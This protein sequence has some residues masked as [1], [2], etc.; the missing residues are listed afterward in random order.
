MNDPEK[1]FKIEGITELWKVDEPTIIDQEIAE[2][3]PKGDDLKT[4]FF[5]NNFIPNELQK[6]VRDSKYVGMSYK[7]SNTEMLMQVSDHEREAVGDLT[8]TVLLVATNIPVDQP[9]SLQENSS[10]IVLLRISGDVDLPYD[11][12][13]INITTEF[14]RQGP[15]EQRNCL[16]PNT[17]FLIGHSGVKTKVLGQFWLEN[18]EK[19]KSVLRFGGDQPIYYPYRPMQV[20]KPCG[21]ALDKII[22]YGINAKT[23]FPIGD[24]RYCSSKRNNSPGN[25]PEVLVDGWDFLCQKTAL[26]GMTRQGKSNSV[27]QI[28]KNIYH[29]SLDNPD[30]PSV[31]QLIFDPN[32]EYCHDNPQDGSC[33]RNMPSGNKNGKTSDVASYGVT[34]HLHDPDRKLLKLNFLHDDLISIGKEILNVNLA[35]YEQIYIQG[36]LA[37]DIELVEPASTGK[38]IRY[39]RLKL[40]YRILLISSGFRSHQDRFSIRGLFSKEIRDAMINN[41]QENPEVIRAGEILSQDCASSGQLKLAFQG[42]R[43]FIKD[44]NSGYDT[45]N[46]EYIAGREKKGEL[47]EGWA[48][49]H[50]KNIL[51]M[52]FNSG[53]RLLGNFAHLHNPEIRS[54]FCSEIY[55]DLKDGKTVIVD[56]TTGSEQENKTVANR[57]IKYIFQQNMSE[58]TKAKIPP[59]IQLYIEEAH[60]ILP[61]GEKGNGDNVWVRVAR[62]GAKFNIGMA[63][64]TQ[65]VSSIHKSILSQTAN[66]FISF[67]NNHDDRALLKKY[68]DFGDFSEAIS[69]SQDQ[70]FARIKMRSARF[71]VPTQIHKF[72][73]QNTQPADIKK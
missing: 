69:R 70:G 18:T 48:D 12:E 72:F 23:S 36:F 13:K 28:V 27:K 59:Y 57:I 71:T 24:L 50:L 22:N 2:I 54:D 29:L 55:T 8:D 61:S 64:S 32:G 1:E 73:I 34:P 42:L 6:M 25:Y 38:V 16:D 14:S 17:S 56:Q 68:F 4:T 67:L 65:E 37:T 40:A 53:E 3:I 62:E 10:T 31:G 35:G 26:F 19:N 33:I 21:E 44:R 52:F 45:F 58:F 20:F 5:E 41:S 39:N 49:V 43:N 9:L 51:E 66:F 47:S 7:I 30:F 15:Q 63:Y 11:I 46:E 60:T